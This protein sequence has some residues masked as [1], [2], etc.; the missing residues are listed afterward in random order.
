MSKQSKELF[1]HL[2]ITVLNFTLFYKKRNNH[3]K[4]SLSASALPQVSALAIQKLYFCLT[5]LFRNNRISMSN[6][7]IFVSVLIISYLYICTSVL[8]SAVYK[9]HLSCYKSQNSIKNFNKRKSIIN[10]I[11]FN[12]KS[13]TK[14]KKVFIEAHDYM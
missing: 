6:K 10:K 2:E 3:L 4:I 5:K 7:Y 9:E 8:K 11:R 1:S 14:F 13:F 12:K